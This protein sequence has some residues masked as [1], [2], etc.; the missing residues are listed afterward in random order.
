[1]NYLLFNPLADN[2]NGEKTA[3]EAKEK[4]KERFGE[5]EQR[6]VFELDSKKFAGCL[7]K[8][9]TLV[10]V[11]GDGTINHMANEIKDI[12]VPCD[13]YVYKA[14]TG[15]DFLRDVTDEIDKD[16]LLLINKYI[17]H[18]PKVTINGKTTLFINGIGFGID[19]QVCEV[20]DDMKA[21]GVKKISYPGISVKLAL[22]KYKCPKA[23]V[24][25]DGKEINY[26]RVWLASAMNGRFY[27]GGMMVC[28]LKIV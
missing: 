7:T 24:K 14:G 4:L 5:M 3:L 9:D 11:G 17:K 23:V 12:N 10:L 20:A 15:N 22:F 6:N 13:I 27:G 21:K 19:G 2:G 25:V 26:K 8:N 1:M 28:L 16:G 18:L